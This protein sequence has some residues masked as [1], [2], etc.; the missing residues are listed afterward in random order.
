MNIFNFNKMMEIFYRHIFQSKR[1]CQDCSGSRTMFPDQK[2]SDLVWDGMLAWNHG[3][4]AQ[5][6]AHAEFMVVVKMLNRKKENL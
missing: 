4:D 1:L 3:C 2:A 6:T 5:H